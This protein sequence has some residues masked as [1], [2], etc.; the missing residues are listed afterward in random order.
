MWSKKKFETLENLSKYHHHH[1]NCMS[2]WI[3]ARGVDVCVCVR[4]KGQIHGRMCDREE[5]QKRGIDLIQ[6]K[7]IIIGTHLDE[8]Q[9]FMEIRMWRANSL[10][11]WFFSYKMAAKCIGNDEMFYIFSCCCFFSLLL[12][13]MCIQFRRMRKENLDQ[14]ERKKERKNLW[15][16]T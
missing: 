14:N 15:C 2:V 1:Q 13:Y 6:W 8:K 16:G 9:C 4:R 10:L 7:C 12:P 11:L 3:H 5:Q